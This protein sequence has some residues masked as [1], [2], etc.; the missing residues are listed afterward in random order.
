[1]DAAVSFITN[2]IVSATQKFVP[3]CVPRLSRPTPWWNC[4]CETV[5]Q[6]KMECWKSG[7]SARFCRVSLRATSI[8][9]R[10]YQTNLRKK[11][12]NCTGSKQWWSL[13]SSL[14][15]H[16]YRGQPAV[17]PAHQLA[18]CFSS[19]LSCSS[20]LDEPPTLEECHHSTFHQ[21]RIKKSQVK[22]VL[23]S[24][25]V[26]KSVGDDRVS[27]R[28]L[29]SF[30]CGPLTTLFHM[31]CQHSDFPT[32]WKIRR[33]TPVFKKGSRTDP[34]CYRPIAVLPALLCV[35]EKL[36]VTQ[37]RRRIDPHIPR[38]QF[39][40]MKGSSTSDAGVLLASTITT[41]IN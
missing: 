34:T 13:L 10:K 32:S 37:F 30:L 21:F 33:V 8:Y 35:F 18:S 28:I 22:S 17:P 19:K 39:G 20:T 7:D 9:T 16:S 41:A 2:V 31:I 25:D 11:L 15:G 36:L 38:E 1:M 27:P 23:Q 4:D 6:K 40:F 5:W 3:S 12:G 14:A 24:L 26:A 29:N